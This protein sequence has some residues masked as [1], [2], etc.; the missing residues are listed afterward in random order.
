MK[1]ERGKDTK[2]SLKLGRYTEENLVRRITESLQAPRPR[3]FPFVYIGEN[4]KPHFFKWENDELGFLYLYSENPFQYK[5]A[6][7]P[8]FPGYY[9]HYTSGLHYENL[10]LPDF[11]RIY[12][13][14]L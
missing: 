7:H 5:W 8:E 2:K 11:L 13:I 12:N 14:K 10:S 9:I 6:D 1:F 3:P 4:L